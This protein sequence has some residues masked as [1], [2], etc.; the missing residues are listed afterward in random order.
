MTSAK[1][2]SG[3]VQCVMQGSCHHLHCVALTGKVIRKR[4]LDDADASKKRLKFM[5]KELQATSTPPPVGVVEKRWKGGKRGVKDPRILL[6]WLDFSQ[7]L[8]QQRHAGLSF[9]R[10]AALL[11]ASGVANAEEISAKVAK[12]GGSLLVKSRVALDCTANIFHRQWRASI[13][14][15]A[16]VSIHIFCDASPQWRGIELFATSVDCIIGGQL[17]RRLAP[18]VSLS[19]TQM[20]HQGKLAALLWQLFL[21]TGPSFSNMRKL[22]T[23]VRSVTTDL[24]TERLLSDSASCLPDFFEQTVSAKPHDDEPSALLFSRCL[25]VPGFRHMVDNLL[26]QRPVIDADLSSIPFEAEIGGEV[27]EE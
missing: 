2:A 10:F 19:K 5:R 8:K 20:G 13:C 6:L 3:L 23:A 17:F 18:L 1:F 7:G 14:D 4:L 27:P 21:M 15:E 9:K 25:H 24:G 22:C 11:T 12:A 16:G 26:Q